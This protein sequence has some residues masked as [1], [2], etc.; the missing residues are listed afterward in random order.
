[1]KWKLSFILKIL[2]ILNDKS[3]WSLVQKKHFCDIL[4]FWKRLLTY[5]SLHETC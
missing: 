4:R 2:M 3:E 5:T 1:M